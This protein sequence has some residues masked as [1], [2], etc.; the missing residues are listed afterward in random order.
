MSTDTPDPQDGTI[1]GSAPYRVR[2][3]DTPIFD[4]WRGVREYL[5]S[6]GLFSP[7]TRRQRSNIAVYKAAKRR[8]QRIA[9]RF[10]HYRT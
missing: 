3:D 4:S 5:F 1:P 6:S 7:L 10:P 2:T 9:H 8:C